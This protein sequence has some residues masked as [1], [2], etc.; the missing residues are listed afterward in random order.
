MTNFLKSK[1]IILDDVL[2]QSECQELIQFYHSNGFTHEWN[3]TF[4]MTIDLNNEFLNK[5]VKK[6]EKAVNEL[7]PKKL[8]ADWSQ[9][10]KWPTK[11]Y[12]NPHHDFALDQTVFTSITYL[13]DDY[14]GGK[15]FFVDD[16]KVTP[17][18]G[19]TVCFDGQF[20]EHGVSEIVLGERYTLPIWYNE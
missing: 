5:N 13:N 15:T 20:Y 8:K 17:K 9:I 12:H 14:A 16:M 1:I 11:S 19:R 10:V 2:S 7:L 6:I 3:N 18:I 4:P